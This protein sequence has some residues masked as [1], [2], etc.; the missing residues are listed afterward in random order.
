MVYMSDFCLGLR[1][2]P[3]DGGDGG[4]DGTFQRADAGNTVATTALLFAAVSEALA[5]AVL[6]SA[7]DMLDL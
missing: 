6:F 3:I 5:G 7:L 4:R 1:A 2:P